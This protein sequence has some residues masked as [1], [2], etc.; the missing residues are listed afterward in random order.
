MCFLM[1]VN[2]RN[3][4]IY[5]F[6]ICHC[7]RIDQLKLNCV[8]PTSGSSY[9]AFFNEMDSPGTTFDSSNSGR[10]PSLFL[11]A[12]HYFRMDELNLHVAV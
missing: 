4:A 7:L 6:S 3:R 12:T 5:P 1:Y 2:Y 10:L 8:A 9:H 11:F